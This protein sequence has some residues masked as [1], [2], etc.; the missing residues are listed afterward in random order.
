MNMTDNIFDFGDVDPIDIVESLAEHYKWD[1][2]KV[3][4]E[5]RVKNRLL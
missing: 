5:A 3:L 4:L 1:F 2:D